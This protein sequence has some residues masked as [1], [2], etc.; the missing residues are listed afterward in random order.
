MMIH[1]GAYTTATEKILLPSKGLYVGFTD[2]LC[3][4]EDYKKKNKRPSLSPSLKSLVKICAHF[5]FIATKYLS[6]SCNHCKYLQSILKLNCLN[7]SL[8]NEIMQ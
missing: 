8:S 6:D 1:R 3:G 4:G 5:L 2:C 7:F